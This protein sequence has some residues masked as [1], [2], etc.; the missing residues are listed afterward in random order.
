M[1]KKILIV[2]GDERQSK[3]LSFLLSGTGFNTRSYSSGEK[4]LEALRKDSYDLVITDSHVPENKDKL[5]F[6]SKLKEELPQ[7]PVLLITGKKELNEVIHSI[8]SGVTDIIDG[9]SDYKRVLTE[10]HR[11]VSTWDDSHYEI[12]KE[13]MA[14][15][16]H[17]LASIASSSSAQA[18]APS[19]DSAMKALKKEVSESKSIIQSLN[20]SNQ[21]L[22]KSKQRLEDILAEFEKEGS[23]GEGGS[24]ARTL[25]R[26]A[27]LDTREAKLKETNNRLSKQRAEMEIKMSELEDLKYIIEEQQAKGYGPSGNSDKLEKE[28]QELR[29][30]NDENIAK[31]NERRLELEANI[32]DLSRE[33][34]VSKNKSQSI[35][36]MENKILELRSELQDTREAIAEKDFV[37]K[38][39]D[40]QI[41][42]L[43]TEQDN[44]P[45]PE[46]EEFE[47]QKRLFE[48]ERFKLQEK[49]DRFERDRA[50]F[51]RDHE[52]NRRELQVERKDA[53]V[54]LREMQTGI[55]EE[56]LKLHVEKA[57]Y[58]EEQRQF[59]RARQNFQEDVQDLQRKQ[60]ELRNYEEKLKNFE[61]NM[62]T[63]SDSALPQSPDAMEGEIGNVQET[64][65]NPQKPQGE[66]GNPSTWKK[67]P[68][69]KDKARG[70]LRIGRRSS[71]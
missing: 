23:S 9:G 22:E 21:E 57:S 38:Q 24:S 4:A 43:Q 6:V 52:K 54:S 45:I 65:A 53:E 51:D 37:I 32:Q 46:L 15:V 13:D 33:L 56:Q 2:R 70:P 47:E 8:R 55:K 25:E 18:S 67:P 10:T 58:Q 11:F 36:Q 42:K 49:F 41:E 27:L 20:A 66:K 14:E 7:L 12:S 28:L 68:S 34:E 1:N 60:S 44:A 62:E 39:R 29:A 30:Q 16:E 40:S 63:G 50:D 61:K 26:E 5:S 64:A 19:D 17:V 71:F 59:E 69:S 31:A 35:D 48:I 3:T